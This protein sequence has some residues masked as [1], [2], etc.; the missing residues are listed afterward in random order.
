[1][2]IFSL[3]TVALGLGNIGYL[4][5]TVKER[6]GLHKEDD[7][8]DKTVDLENDF[9]AMAF[10]VAFT[11]LMR[12]ILTG[13]HPVDDDSDFDHTRAQR[14]GMFF[15]A[16]A[17][18]IIAGFAISFCSKKAADPQSSMATQRVMNFCS[19]VATMNV[20]WAWLYWG[21]WEFFEA[22]YPGEAVK[23]RVMFAITMTMLGGC[24]LIGLSKIKAGARGPEVKSEKKV[25]LT[26]LALVIAWSW[27]LCFDA[28]I[29]DMC[30]GV[31]HPVAWKVLTTFSLASIVIPVYAYYMKPIS[32]KAYEEIGA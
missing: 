32:M 29:E 5:Y 3:C 6:T 9:G 2:C 16:I 17:C 30:A 28:A 4:T 19:T 23:G 22:L 21:E 7:Y 14:T 8:M 11:M 26:A 27:E 1:M 18:F 15:Y 25:A 12:F 31:D 24:G 13:H 10:S 20:A